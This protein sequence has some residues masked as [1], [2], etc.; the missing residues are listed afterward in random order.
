MARKKKVEAAPVIEAAPVMEES[1]K[2]KVTNN[3]LSITELNGV[4]Y[5]GSV[6]KDSIQIGRDEY[7]KMKTMG[8]NVGLVPGA[9]KSENVYY[10]IKSRK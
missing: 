8:L 3:H 7:V 9:K 6:P 4:V 1:P 10:L 5:G 2:T